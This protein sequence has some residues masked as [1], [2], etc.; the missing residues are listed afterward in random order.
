[1]GSESISCHHGPSRDGTDV[2]TTFDY[3]VPR[4]FGGRVVDRVLIQKRMYHDFE[5]SMDNLRLLAETSP[6]TAAA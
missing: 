3:T 4:R 2:T 6:V 1:M 5:D